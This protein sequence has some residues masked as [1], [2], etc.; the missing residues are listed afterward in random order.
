MTPIGSRAAPFLLAA[1]CAGLVFSTTAAYARP[2]QDNPSPLTE[3]ALNSVS[4]APGTTAAWAAGNSIS[5]GVSGSI[6]HR[7][8]GKWHSVHYTAPAGQAHLND[9]AA[10]STHAIWVVGAV[11]GFSTESAL[12]LHSTGGAFAPTSIP[13]ATSGSALVSVAASS[14]T[15]AWAVGNNVAHGIVPLA[16]RLVGSKWKSVS[17]PHL[18]AEYQLE[19]VTTSS[20][21]NTWILAPG[22]ANGQAAL[23][24]WN[25]KKWSKTMLSA[26]PKTGD[27]IA[28]ATS[29]P[30][31]AWVVGFTQTSPTKSFSSRWNGQKWS[32]VAVPGA[33]S[34]LLDVATVGKAAFAVGN[35]ASGPVA[36][37][38]N[39]GKWHTERTDKH[40]QNAQLHGIGASSKL[41][42]AVGS[43]ESG[44]TFEPL[45]DTRVGT[46]WTRTAA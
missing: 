17:L 18:P 46:H 27:A 4:V 3:L 30:Q 21:A 36:L 31:S 20:A 41:D 19:S 32:I 43:D 23:L 38:F 1:S 24:H 45:I 22:P 13:N 26:I 39:A 6:L 25:G 35:G 11:Q 42:L 2:A 16:Y 29:G 34:D 28:I 33:A 8:S 37:H 40:G 15:N 9:V 5:D 12:L 10:G 44:S 7:A 14:A